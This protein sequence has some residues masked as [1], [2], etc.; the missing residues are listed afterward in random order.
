M[1]IK[2]LQGEEEKKHGYYYEFDMEA[3]PIGE[4]G[5]GKVYKGFRVNEVTGVRTPVAIKAMFDD[6]PH[7][8]Y[9]RA[10]R[11]ASIQLHN[12]NLIEMLGFVADSDVNALGERKIHYH[13]ISEF[14]NGVVLSDLLYGKL[15]DKDGIE[16]PFARQLY[17]QYTA[18][19]E[20]AAVHITKCVLSGI[21]ALH[22]KG[23]IH[24]DIDPSNIMVTKEGN[25]KLIDFGIAKLLNTLGSH[26][27]SVTTTGKFIGKAEY[28]SPELVLGDVHHQGY[29]TDIYAIGILFYQLLTGRLPFTGSK[30]EVLQH[31]LKTPLP[32]SPVE[33]RRYRKIIK[34][35]T[36][37]RQI[38]RYVSAAEFRVALDKDDGGSGWTDTWA[39]KLPRVAVAAGVAAGIGVA[40]Y[41]L[42]NTS[43][44]PGPDPAHAT[45]QSAFEAEVASSQEVDVSSEAPAPPAPE[46]AAILPSLEATLARLNASA[47][48][49]VRLGFSQIKLLAD[50]GRSARAMYELG[51]TYCNYEDKLDPAIVQRRRILGFTKENTSPAESI[52]WLEKAYEQDSTSLPTIYWLGYSYWR[53]KAYAKAE[54]VLSRAAETGNPQ[55][56]EYGYLQDESRK[57]LHLSK[58]QLNGRKEV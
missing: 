40:A 47:A 4:G 39:D 43:S 12:D 36:A 32:L 50:S 15:T 20:K 18:D 52:S 26:D 35:A 2:R 1:R 58:K 14:L 29:T 46:L 10:R 23:Y 9:E 28:A 34:K 27:K 13:V 31:Q 30:F 42:W 49:S 16:I 33:P 37:K 7:E 41:F 54:K 45:G 11:E 38:D 5:M 55:S 57:Y 3:Q 19:R 6:L 25:I 24:R 56:K 22:D 8:V 44:L 21:M 51:L 53:S 17:T 48:D